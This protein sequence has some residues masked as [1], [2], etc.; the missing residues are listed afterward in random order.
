[1]RYFECVVD[2]HQALIDCLKPLLTCDI[3]RAIVCSTRALG[4]YYKNC[5]PL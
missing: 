2:C 5:A 1:V 3:G 4:C